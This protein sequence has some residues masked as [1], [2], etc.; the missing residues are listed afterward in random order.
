MRRPSRAE[1]LANAKASAEAV[2]AIAYATKYHSDWLWK[3]CATDKEVVRN[4]ALARALSTRRFTRCYCRSSRW[5]AFGFNSRLK[6]CETTLPF[7]LKGG[8]YG[9]QSHQCLASCRM[10]RHENL[11]LINRPSLIGRLDQEP[12]H[13]SSFLTKGLRPRQIGSS[14]VWA[15]SVV[16][17]PGYCGPDVRA[18]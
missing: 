8:S 1:R 6:L 4:G 15:P 12:N 17:N 13:L 14:L 10:H 3:G 7:Q 2:N 11:V 18:C 16:G 9:I 5:V